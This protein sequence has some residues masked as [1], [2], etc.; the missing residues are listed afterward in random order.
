MVFY[1]GWPH[2]VFIK[3]GH[4]PG[5]VFYQGWSSLRVYGNGSLLIIRG[6]PV[7]RVCLLPVAVIKGV[8]YQGMACYQEWSINYQ[9]A[10]CYQGWSIIKGWSINYQWAACYQGWSIIKR[11]SINYQGVACYQGAACN[12]GWSINYQG[13]A[14]YQGWSVN[15][16]G[17][18]W[19]QGWS[20]IREWLV[21]RDGPSSR[22]VDYNQRCSII[23][24]GQLLG[25]IYYQQ[26]SI[27]ITP[28][29]LSGGGLAVIRGC[30]SSRSSSVNTT[31]LNTDTKQNC[32]FQLAVCGN[33]LTWSALRPTGT[34]LMGLGEVLCLLEASWDSSCTREKLTCKMPQLSDSR[35]R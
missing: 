35:S 13:V 12:Q 11:W 28:C 23:R 34:Q 29:R 9:W 30:P 24:G 16:Q 3:D 8:C 26:W 18:A 31:K 15:Y 14:C 25:V 17:V 22:V 32:S 5:V 2:L 10:A 27:I 6:W 20:I 33:R 4:S 7:I 1:Q 19:Y 21:L